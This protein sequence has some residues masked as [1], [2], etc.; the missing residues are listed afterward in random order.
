MTNHPTTQGAKIV[1]SCEELLAWVAM[2]EGDVDHGVFAESCTRILTRTLAVLNVPY[3]RTFTQLRGY[4]ALDV[5][6]A[7]L[8]PVTPKARM[9]SASAWDHRRLPGAAVLNHRDEDEVEG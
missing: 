5:A 7:L 4:A 3:V 9:P 2:S 8:R 1:D 6:P